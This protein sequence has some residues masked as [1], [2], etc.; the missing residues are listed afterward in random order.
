MRVL[1]GLL[2]GLLVSLQALA[3]DLGSLSNADAGSG[4]KDALTQGT[5]SAVSRLGAE[6]GFLGNDKVRIPLPDALKRVEG[7]MRMLGLQKQAEE[8][9]TAMNRAAEQ[10][11]PL[12][13]P[14]LLNA[15]KNMSWQDAK[16]ILAGSDTAATEYFRRTTSDQLTEKFLPIVS[17]ATANVGLAEKYNEIAGKGAKL[18]LL[19]AKQARIENY[20]TQK[21]L[22]GLFLMLAEQ[23][24]AI[25]AD[26]IGAATAMARRV[27]GL[28]AK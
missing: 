26:P 14:L 9:V 6:N 2:A 24:K 1:A 20:V 22:D 28:A 11:V 12:A 18:G 15:V 13:K 21:A 27:F 5:A 25:R 17:K 4:L 10:A 3:L 16:G 19:D 7:A 8:L 23:E